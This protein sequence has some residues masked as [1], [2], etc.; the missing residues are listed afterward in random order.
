MSRNQ[1]RHDPG[2]SRLRVYLKLSRRP[3]PRRQDR[4]VNGLTVA[5]AMPFLALIGEA[6]WKPGWRRAWRRSYAG[7]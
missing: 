5:L 4:L 7:T 1:S 6:I 2:R 3:D